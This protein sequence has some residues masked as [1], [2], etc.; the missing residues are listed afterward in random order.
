MKRTLPELLAEAVE[1]EKTITVNS[2]DILWPDKTEFI[3][4]LEENRLEQ[5]RL[6]AEFGDVIIK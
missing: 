1:K 2:S 5:I 4:W 6:S 3:A